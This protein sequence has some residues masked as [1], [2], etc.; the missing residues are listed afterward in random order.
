MQSSRPK[1]ISHAGGN[2]SN[3]LDSV[4]VHFEL[5]F[6]YDDFELNATAV[7]EERI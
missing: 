6:V 3:F 1:A 7:N 5:A 4:P 2:A